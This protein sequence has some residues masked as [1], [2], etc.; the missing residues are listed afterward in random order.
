MIS[1]DPVMTPVGGAD[2]ERWLKVV[3]D[4]IAVSFTRAEPRRRAW[5]Y[6]LDLPKARATGLR[7]G[8]SV[9]RH[10]GE[11]ADGVQ[12]LLTTAQWDESSVRDE[13]RSIATRYGGTNGGTLFAI[14]MAFP[15]KGD[16]AAAVERQYSGDTKKAENC[17]VGVML[18]HLTVTGLAFLID[19]ELYL[20]QSWA[21]DAPRRTRAGIPPEVGYRS[22]STIAAHMITRALAAG[23]RP[24][25]VALSVTCGEKGR[26][27]QTLRKAHIPHVFASSSVEL[28]TGAFG[29]PLTSPNT[30]ARPHASRPGHEVLAHGRDVLHRFACEPTE[31]SRLEVSFLATAAAGSHRRYRAHFLAAMPREACLAE[32]APV[33][34]LTEASGMFSRQVKEDIGLGHY[35]VRSW[36]GWYRHI[37]LAAAAH[38][39]I[40]LARQHNR[41]PALA[42]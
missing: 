7:G 13:L 16:R 22:R 34:F 1:G 2:Y 19:R 14:E 9:G 33:V 27:H 10:E 12:R 11:R 5:N 15:K 24:D 21:A 38:T 18:F 36:C 30:I 8:D 28:H 40:G 20:P 37:T 31:P 29:R 32:A 25:W 41:E 6:L 4:R 39:A 17:Q 35:E 23:I 26:L 3:H 42:R